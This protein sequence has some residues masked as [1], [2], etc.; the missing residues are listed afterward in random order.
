[1]Y[2][3]ELNITDSDGNVVYNLTN[4]SLSGISDTFNSI[5]NVSGGNIG[6]HTVNLTVWDSHTSELIS[7]YNVDKGKDYIMF[8]DTIKV[9]AVGAIRSDATKLYDKYSFEFEY[10]KDALE[11]KTYYLESDGK[12]DYRNV[13]YKA[14]FVDWKNKKWIDFEGIAGEPTI[15]KMTDSKWKIVFNTAGGLVVFNSIGGLNYNETH[16]QYGLSSGIDNCTIGGYPTINFTLYNE[17][18]DTIINANV[19]ISMNFVFNYNSIIP[20][21]TIAYDDYS[22]STLYNN[23]T[24]CINPNSSSVTSNIT[25]EFSFESTSFLYQIYNL[26]LSNTTRHVRLYVSDGTTQTTLNVKDTFGNDIAGAYILVEKYDIGTNTYKVME[27]V[28]T[29][30]SGDA[31]AQLVLLT[32][33]YRFTIS[34]HGT[35]YLVDGSPAVKIITASRNFRINLIGDDWFDDY[36]L[37]REV[38]YNLTFINATKVFNFRWYDDGTGITSACLKVTEMNISGN[39]HINTTCVTGS[40]SGTILIDV[41]TDVSVVDKTYMGIAFVIINS[42]EFILDT[43]EISFDTTWSIFYEDTIKEQFGVFMTF[44]LCLTLLLIGIWHPTS[45]IIMLMIAMGMARVIGIYK[46]SWPHYITLIILAAFVIARIERA[47]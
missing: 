5:I 10:S 40:Y 24:F 9:T 7:A 32:E 46:I 43:L 44:L 14:H 20:P 11:S 26:N 28:V 37:F 34:Y 13:G 22:L 12:L 17:S 36:N 16:Y 35:V 18:T 25:A 8:D 1:M 30:N 21:T 41:G 29:D 45:A 38:S 2:G 33:W 39:T 19:S 42:E 6:I 31:Y 4:T 15:T 27:S 23:Q 3:F 47:K